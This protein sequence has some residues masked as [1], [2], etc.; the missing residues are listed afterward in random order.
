MQ[1]VG[2]GAVGLGR[3]GYVHARNIA[4]H[5]PRAKLIAVCDMQADL[6]KA[7]AE[8]LGCAYYADVRKM[9]ENKEIDAVCI[10]TPTALHVDPVL[11]VVETQKPLFC[12]KPLADNLVDTLDLARRI[13]AAGIICQMGFQR[14]FDPPFAEAAQMIRAGAIGKPVY[15]NTFARD[16]FPPP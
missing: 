13:K 8:E 1:E 11:A 12:E 3:L 9:L 14:R 16:P 6:A 4:R 7:T 5:V 10:A 2:I 15:F